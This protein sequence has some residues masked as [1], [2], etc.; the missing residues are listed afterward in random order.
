MSSLVSHNTVKET[1]ITK[2]SMKN[3]NEKV[4]NKEQNIGVYNPITSGFIEVDSLKILNIL[5]H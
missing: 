5:L 3:F 4:R 1:G 2:N